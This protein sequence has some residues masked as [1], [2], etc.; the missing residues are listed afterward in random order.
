[1][2]FNSPDTVKKGLNILLVL[3]SFAGYLEWGTHNHIFLWQA[4]AD[5]LY[6]LIVQPSAI[7]HPLII[8]PL[9]AQILLL[10]T[11]F[12]QTPGK[13]ITWTGIAGIGLLLG[14]M[15]IIGCISLNIK[16]A[17][18]ALPFI[19]IAFITIRYHRNHT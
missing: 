13:V 15:F 9:M 16:I 1:M 8:A 5:I 7:M 3:T 6:Q 14:F 19:I 11:L 4:E 10:F 2:Q 18:S 12:Q 17:G